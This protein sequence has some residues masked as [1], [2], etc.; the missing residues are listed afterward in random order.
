V[1]VPHRHIRFQ[2]LGRHIRNSWRGTLVS[3]IAMQLGSFLF[4]ISATLFMSNYI[5]QVGFVLILLL[6]FYLFTLILLVGAE[7][8]AFFAE[9]IHVPKSDLITQASKGGY[10]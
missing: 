6:F 2:T 5:G 4:P 10:E 7:V 1:L 8:N 9:G 3:T